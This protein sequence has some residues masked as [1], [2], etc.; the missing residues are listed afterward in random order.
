MLRVCNSSFVYIKTDI[1]IIFQA[2][3]GPGLLQRYAIGRTMSAWNSS[4][5]IGRPHFGAFSSIM[6]SLKEKGGL[7][8]DSNKHILQVDLFMKKITQRTD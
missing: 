1:D 8:L 7:L 6:D 4:Q 5:P 2:W 3:V